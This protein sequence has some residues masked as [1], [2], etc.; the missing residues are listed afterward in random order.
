MAQYAGTYYNDETEATYTV[1]VKD[2]KLMIRHRKFADAMLTPLATDQF[3]CDNWWMNN[4]KF[5]R[6]KKGIV[7]GFDVNAGRILHLHYGK[8]RSNTDF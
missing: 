3:R 4:L 5:L 8:T 7:T 1:V 2:D 6:D